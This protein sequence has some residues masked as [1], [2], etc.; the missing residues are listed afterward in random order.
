[1]GSLSEL[2]MDICIRSRDREMLTE[3][4]QPS[5]YKLVFEG[6]SPDLLFMFMTVCAHVH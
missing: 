6:F 4:S 3:P 2:K 5:L 1:M